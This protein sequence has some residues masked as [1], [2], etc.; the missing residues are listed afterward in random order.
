MATLALQAFQPAVWFWLLGSLLGLAVSF[1]V[2]FR[3]Y[4]LVGGGVP[5][6][7]ERNQ[8]SLPDILLL[9]VASLTEPE[10]LPWFGRRAVAGK[11]LQNN[12]DS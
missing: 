11:P 9:T 10:P 8:A 12:V 5:H 7:L 6:L 2:A 4:Q 3:V 1:Y